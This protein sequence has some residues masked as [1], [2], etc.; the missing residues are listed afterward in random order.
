[1]NLAILIIL[2]GNEVT[3]DHNKYNGNPEVVEW[4]NL[5]LNRE[6]CNNQDRNME[7]KP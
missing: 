4:G 5:I 1:M 7:N 3:P 2:P 6:Y